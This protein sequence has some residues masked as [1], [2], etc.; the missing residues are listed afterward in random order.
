MNANLLAKYLYKAGDTVKQGRAGSAR[1]PNQLHTHTH[2][3][4]SVRATQFTT[5]LFILNPQEPEMQEPLQFKLLEAR[6]S[7]AKEAVSRATVE[8]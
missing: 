6:I 1:H 5:E 3:Y 4:D 2:M 7:A 8:I